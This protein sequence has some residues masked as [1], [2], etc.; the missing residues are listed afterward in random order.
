MR[1][2]TAGWQSAAIGELLLHVVGP[3]G[4]GMVPQ[5]ILTALALAAHRIAY[6]A[7]QVPD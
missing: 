2:V 1:R 4:T 7:Q 3:N 5:A 6:F